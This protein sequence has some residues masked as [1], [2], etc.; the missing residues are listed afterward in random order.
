MR[1]DF[2]RAL[3]Q[4]AAL[5]RFADARRRFLPESTTAAGDLGFATFTATCAFGGD[6]VKR[7]STRQHNDTCLHGR[8]SAIIVLLQRADFH[9]CVLR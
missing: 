4:K 8:K 3:S 5:A 1:D 6:S 7:V 9:D 2:A